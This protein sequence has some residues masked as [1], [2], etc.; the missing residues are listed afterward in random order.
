MSADGVIKVA[1]FGLS[2]DVYMKNY[3]RISK[4][5]SSV[6]MEVKLPIKW[7]APE[8]IHD[9]LF[10]EKTDVVCMTIAYT[11]EL[12]QYTHTHTSQWSYGVLC[13][14]VFTLGKS[15]YPGM[16]SKEVVDLID[17]GE[18]MD[19]PKNLACTKD[20]YVCNLHYHSRF[21]CNT[22]DLH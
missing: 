16:S 14:E 5:S 20:T 7:M 22:T 19:P 2:E 10:S 9:G 3:F 18:R 17:S 4:D 8:S 11:T 1:D 21:I 12:L 6:G 15:P 13:W